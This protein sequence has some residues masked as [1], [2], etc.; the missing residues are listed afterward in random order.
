ML[1]LVGS[2]TSFEYGREELALLAGLEVTAK[3][4]EH[5]AE[6][7][8]ADIAANEQAEVRRAK[9]LHLPEVCAPSVPQK[10]SMQASTFLSRTRVS[11][12]G[13]A[14]VLRGAIIA[15]HRWESDVCLAGAAG[16]C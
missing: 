6:A 8:G 14:P 3:A 11:H 9:Q 12:A 13:C 5:H 10:R 16:Y 7:I 4:V 15:N 1:A 2:Q